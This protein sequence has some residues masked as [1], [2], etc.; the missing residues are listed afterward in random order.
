MHDGR[1]ATL[2]DVIESY[3]LGPKNSPT[4]DNIMIVKANYRLEN[5]GH[6]GLA[7]SAQ[8]K[9]DLKYF[10]LSMSDT[11]FVN[12]PDFKKPIE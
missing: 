11:S 9:A 6:Y 4:V 7:L 12:N 5:Y 3:N 8:E 1:F 10:L 2:E